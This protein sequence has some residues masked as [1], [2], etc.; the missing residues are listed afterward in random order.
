VHEVAGHDLDP[1]GDVGVHVDVRVEKGEHG[2]HLGGGLAGHQ[3]VSDPGQ[4]HGS[5]GA[6]DGIGHDGAA[7]EDDAVS[8][9]LVARGDEVGNGSSW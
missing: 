6:H 9:Q 8:P 7:V 1:D 5:V 4:R 2:V 3:D